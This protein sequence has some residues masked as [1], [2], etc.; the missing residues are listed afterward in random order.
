[1]NEQPIT[2]G[3]YLQELIAQESRAVGKRQNAAGYISMWPDAVRK[4]MEKFP[5]LSAAERA[6]LRGTVESGIQQLSA[7]FNL[8]IHQFAG[9]RGSVVRILGGASC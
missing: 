4:V 8:D 5:N 1:M 2:P 6:T 7:H 3:S 9:A